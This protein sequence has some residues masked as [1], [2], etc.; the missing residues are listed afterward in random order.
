[1]KITCDETGTP[2]SLAVLLAQLDGDPAVGGILILACDDNHFTPAAVDPAL[3]ATQKPVFG[4]VFPQIIH[5]QKCLTRGTIVV[6]LPMAPQVLLLDGVSQ[7]ERDFDAVLDTATQGLSVA[8]GKTMFIFVDGLATRIGALID[9]LF[10]TFG[11]R[12][13]YLG[14]GCG[15]LSF[16]PK[17]CVMGNQGLVQDAA[18]LAVIDAPSGIGVAHGWQPVSEGFKVTESTGNVI[19]T[20]DWRPAYPVYKE[21]VESHSGLRF[22]D[23]NFFSI[24]KGYPFGIAKLDAEMVVRDPI[25]TQNESLVC[26]GEVPQGT[27]VRILNGNQDSLLSAAARAHDL[28]KEALGSHPAQIEVFVDCISRFLFLEENFDLELN[29]AKDAQLPVV[30]ALTLGEIA[31]NGNDYLEFYNK[32]AVVGLI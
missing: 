29:A 13:N 7:P 30:G 12:I 2:E 26:V 15:S 27:F 14:G 9:A 16:V 28:A 18:V 19:H 17:P 23:S 11:L 10:N 31:N 21:I 3:R 20:L 5:G 32:T 22:D 8:E 6:G 25:M 1:M 24:A 4:G